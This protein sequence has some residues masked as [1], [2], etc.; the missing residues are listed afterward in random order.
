MITFV[1]CDYENNNEIKIFNLENHETVHDLKRQRI[2]FGERICNPFVSF[3]AYNP[4]YN[5]LASVHLGLIKFWNPLTGKLIRHFIAHKKTVENI[6]FNKTGDIMA[7]SSDGPVIKLWHPIEGKLPY[8][9]NAHNRAICCLDFSSKGDILASSST[10]GLIKIWNAR[11]GLLL[12]TFSNSYIQTDISIKF[13]P[14]GNILASKNNYAFGLIFWNPETGTK[15]LTISSDIIRSF[16]FSPDG[17]T[18]AIGIYNKIKFWNIRLDPPQS[19]IERRLQALSED[20]DNLSEDADNL[21]EENGSINSDY[22][23]EDNSNEEN[24][25]INSDYSLEEVNFQN[26]GLPQDYIDNT[27]EIIYGNG[28]YSQVNSISDEFTTL[29]T[30][31]TDMITYNSTGDVIVLLGDDEIEVWDSINREKI[32]TIEVACV[33]NIAPVF[34]DEFFIGPILK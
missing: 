14:D 23:I 28:E 10:D 34:I 26:A 33:S 3:I 20:A 17:K 30:K 18:L 13:S 12:Q 8:V 6:V 7:T 2:K 16:N 24:G 19:V 27:I 1:D 31:N 21:N 25:S 22:S 32:D 15:I 9:L 11:E 5:I 4:N 29:E